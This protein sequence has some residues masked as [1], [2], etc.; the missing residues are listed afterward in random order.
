MHHAIQQ[1]THDVHIVIQEDE[2]PNNVLMTPNLCFGLGGQLAVGIRN[3]GSV[4]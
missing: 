4:R 1:P 2:A 3:D